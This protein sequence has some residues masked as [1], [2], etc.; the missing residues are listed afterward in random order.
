MKKI[1]SILAA[2][3]L[4]MVACNK[5]GDVVPL[6]PAPNDDH[7]ISIEVNNCPELPI[8]KRDGTTIQDKVV[9]VDMPAS[10]T[11]LVVLE[12]LGAQNFEFEALSATRAEVG[13]AYQIK[14][15]GT[16]T[17][18]AIQNGIAT[19]S[20]VP[21][22]AS[23]SL[24]VFTGKIVAE[25]NKGKLY[26]DACRGWTVSETWVSI[27]GEGISADLGV[28]K[29]FIGCNINEIS[30]YAIEK[31]VKIEEQPASYTVDKLIL[32]DSG[33]FAIIFKGEEP[34]YGDYQLS[35][36]FFSYDFEY[37]DED[38]PIIAAKASGE[39]KIL[40]SGKGRLAVTGNLKDSNG[41]S[42]SAEI[43]FFLAPEK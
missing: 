41:K 23:A 28:A 24:L 38:D 7:H 16:F 2:A 43:I 31:G 15:L 32:T 40:D 35:E 30:K 42:Y 1:F 39:F 25:P 36:G 37:Y 34:Y 22:G 3:S 11:G 8:P 10:R 13:S 21:E 5:G 20:F 29:K 14:D 19:I 9:R 12:K 27:K 33:K 17:I 18:D 4:V 26:D 6:P